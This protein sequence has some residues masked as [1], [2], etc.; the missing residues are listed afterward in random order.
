M[1]EIPNA[2]R[3]RFAEAF[4]VANTPASLLTWL[5]GDPTVLR[6]ATSE[7][8][9][10]II[11]TLLPLLR[12]A[13]RSE[14]QTGTAYGLLVALGLRRRSNLGDFALPCRLTSLAWGDEIWRR[15]A[16][17][18]VPTTRIERRVVQ[19]ATA[20]VQRA[21]GGAAV[22][23]DVNGNRVMPEQGE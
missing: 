17:S 21:D 4:V 18:Y 16:R 10:E 3:D 7:T 6:V 1:I 11:D 14:S 23:L 20:N 15:L 2:D 12:A 22:I 13:H 9:E 19:P 8:D 5:E